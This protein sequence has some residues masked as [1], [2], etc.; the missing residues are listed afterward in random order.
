M[1]PCL[2]KGYS[3]RFSFIIRTKSACSTSLL[4][5]PIYDKLKDAGAQFGAA[6][7]DPLWF[8]PEGVSD[9]FSWRRSVD[10]DHVGAEA[11]A[12]RNSV[13]L[14]ETSGFANTPV[15]AEG[16]EEYLDKILACRIQADDAC[17]NAQGRW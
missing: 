2:S 17:S 1:A 4:T 15:Q 11:N 13:G 7:L 6:V 16:A 9:V 12:V 3:R 8:A 5:T 10:F 14:L